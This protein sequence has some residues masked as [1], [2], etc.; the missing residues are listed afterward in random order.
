[1]LAGWLDRAEKFGQLVEILLELKKEN[2]CDDYDYEYD[3][4]DTLIW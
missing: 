4:D 1:M 2:D 3:D